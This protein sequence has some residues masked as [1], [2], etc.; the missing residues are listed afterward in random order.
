MSDW[1]IDT[2]D[3]FLKFAQETDRVLLLSKKGIYQIS[4]QM[5][6]LK[7]LDNLER[8]RA[9]QAMKPFQPKN[10][11]SAETETKFARQEI[12]KE[13]PL[14]HAHAL[15]SIWS[16]ME[17]LFEDV[18]V[19]HIIHKPETLKED[20]FQKIRIPL[21]T[22]EQL[23]QEDKARLLV[24]ELQRSL[25]SDQRLGLECFEALLRVVGL[26]G[27]VKTKIRRDIFELQQLR[28]SIVHRASL[29]DRKLLEAC[30]WLKLKSGDRI[31]ISNKQ[32]RRLV[33]AAGKYVIAVIKRA[34]AIALRRKSLK[35]NETDKL[36]VKLN[37][38]CSA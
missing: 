29:A 2:F 23:N 36:K 37:P 15:V 19:G 10:L 31:R 17:A 16:A 22:Y 28:H 14:L 30:P 18:L 35:R 38:P 5:P 7:A 24:N 25:S 32:Y 34:T 1:F 26:A 21:A 8:V 6:L 3:R 12:K 13:F 33:D 27:E 9:E 11:E 4:Q 20:I